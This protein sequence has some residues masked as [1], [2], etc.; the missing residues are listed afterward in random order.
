LIFFNY[1]L[2][3]IIYIVYDKINYFEREIV[4]ISDGKFPQYNEEKSSV[5]FFFEKPKEIKMPEPADPTGGAGA[6]GEISPV[7]ETIPPPAE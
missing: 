2:F 7:G 6:A 5:V 4:I 1:L 3:N